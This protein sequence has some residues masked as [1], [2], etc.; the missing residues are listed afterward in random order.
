MMQ[1]PIIVDAKSELLLFRDATRAEVYLEA[2]DVRNGT[3][4]AAYD[5]EGKA[6][7]LATQLVARRVFVCLLPTT[8]EWASLA[9]ADHEADSGLELRELLKRHVFK[10]EAEDVLQKPLVELVQMAVERQGFTA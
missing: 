4:S 10:H 6:L 9:A 1:P 3:Y 5:S 7:A 2:V 8:V